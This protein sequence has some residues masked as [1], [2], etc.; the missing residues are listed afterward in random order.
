MAYSYYYKTVIKF[1]QLTPS[2]EEKLD[3]NRNIMF[4]S[5]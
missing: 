3:F 2:I 5:E 4:Q 1:H